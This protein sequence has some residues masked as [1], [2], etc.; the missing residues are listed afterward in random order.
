MAHLKSFESRLYNSKQTSIL[1]LA[2]QTLPPVS[3]T[4]ATEWYIISV[5]PAPV[6]A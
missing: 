4:L 1:G 5:L 6:T 2:I 3:I